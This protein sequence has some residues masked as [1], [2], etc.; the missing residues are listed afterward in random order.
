MQQA[1][2]EEAKESPVIPSTTGTTV[3]VLLIGPSFDILGGQAV[4]A[5]RLMRVLSDVPGQQM[6]FFPINPRPPKAL[7]W[8]RKIPFVRTIVNVILFHT[9]LFFEARKH[10]ILHIF[11]AGLHSYTLWTIPALLYGKLWGKKIIV[12]YRDGQAEEHI[13]GWR[14]ALPTLRMAD[15]IITPSSFL[16]DVFAKH[17]IKAKSIVNVI[18]AGNFIYRKRRKLR[19]VFMT[20]RILEPLYNVD[21][22]LRAFKIIQTK[23]PEASLTIAHDGVCRPSLEKFAQELEL[24]NTQFIGRVPHKKVAEL[25]DSADIYLTTPNIDCMPG[26]L[27][28]CFAS[29]LPVVAT[30]AGGIPYIAKDR[31]TAL[32]VDINDHEALAARSIELLENEDLV[33]KLTANARQEVKL[34]DWKPVR[35][36]W[37]ELYREVMQLP[38]AR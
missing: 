27:L 21:C 13:T 37:S 33:E 16:V 35:D 8:V 6:T 36:Q 32:L 2:T 1:I 38:A 7:L 18:D 25:Y 5:S 4:Q 26:S 14:T 22:I 12:N 19:P 23:Y 9:R 34:Y 29:G 17:G 15:R 24:K 30:S 31:Y 10:D 28:E 20:N 11:S 3:S